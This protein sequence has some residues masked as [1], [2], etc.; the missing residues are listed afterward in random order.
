MGIFNNK[1]SALDGYKA[2]LSHFNSGYDKTPTDNKKGNLKAILMLIR[3]VVKQPTLD[4]DNKK[5]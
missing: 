5:A 2:D 4:K 1:P 3:C